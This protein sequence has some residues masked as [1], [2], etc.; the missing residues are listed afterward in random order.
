MEPKLIELLNERGL[1]FDY[2]NCSST[3]YIFGYDTDGCY[4]ESDDNTARNIYKAES[5]C[6]NYME[7]WKE[8]ERVEA[9]AL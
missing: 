9:L 5:D 6:L 4:W 3:W 2:D 8:M 1:H 7:T